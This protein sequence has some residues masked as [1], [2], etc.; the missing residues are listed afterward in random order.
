MS[1][2]VFKTDLFGKSIG[3]DWQEKLFEYKNNSFTE[4][5]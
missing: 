5:K 4:Y 1:M 3:N 2:L